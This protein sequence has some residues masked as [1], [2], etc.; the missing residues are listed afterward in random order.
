MSTQDNKIPN[1]TPPR[2]AGVSGA[3]E[4]LS[5]PADPPPGE[6]VDLAGEPISADQLMQA[7]SKRIA[8]LEAE[9][10]EI[11]DRWMRAEA[12]TQNVR[13]RAR[14]EVEETRQ[15][16]VQSFAR[17]VVEAAENLKRGLDSIPPPT[18][19]EPEIV[20]RLRDGFAGV[21]RSVI[22]L[23][24]RNGIRRQDPV[25]A[26]FDPNLHQ[27]MAEQESLEHPPGTVLQS[28]SGGWTL[29]GRLLRPAMVVVARAPPAELPAAG[30]EP[31]GQKLNTTA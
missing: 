6:V 24:E 15:F 12:E 17:D 19:G 30:K 10:A 31:A 28:W 5:A 7:A 25:G 1:V 3:A 20:S 2:S 4:E 26:L 8:D 14:R 21:E 18:P 23:L 9:F 11:R 22:G 29:N 16:A 13:N 27:A